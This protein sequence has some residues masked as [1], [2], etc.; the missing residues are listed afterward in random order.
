VNADMHLVARS[1]SRWAALAIVL[2][3]VLGVGAIG[4]GSALMIGPNGEIL[5]LPVVALAGSPFANYFMPGAILF[6]ILGVGTIVAAILSLRRHSLAPWLA[7]AVGGALVVWIAVE[8]AIVGYSNHPP[9]QL[10]YLGLGVVITLVAVA[11]I[12]EQSRRRRAQVPA[13]SIRSQIAR[14][15]EAHSRACVPGRANRTRRS[16]SGSPMRLARSSPT[17]A[18]VIESPS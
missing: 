13:I 2:E 6:S 14:R 5:P 11:W 8:I 7:L 15:N 3:L 4:G 10:I 17:R 16:A 9:L 18:S 12:R 1:P